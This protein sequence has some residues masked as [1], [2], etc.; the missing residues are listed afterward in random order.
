MTETNKFPHT[1]TWWVSSNCIVH[2][3]QWHFTSLMWNMVQPSL[4]TLLEYFWMRFECNS[5]L[6]FERC[7]RAQ[8][9]S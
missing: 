6:Q 3:N 7:R 1:A 2:K 4:C 5:H 9:S 8:K